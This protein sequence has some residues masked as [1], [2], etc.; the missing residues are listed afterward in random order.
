MSFPVQSY[1]IAIAAGIIDEAEIGTSN[2]WVLAEPK[3][4]EKALTELE[5]LPKAM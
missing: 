2:I 4:I 1:L 5:D 3:M